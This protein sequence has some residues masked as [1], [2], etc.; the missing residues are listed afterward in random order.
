MGENGNGEQSHAISLYVNNKPG[1]L[2]RIGLVFS[3]RGWN[4]DSLCVSPGHDGHFSRMSIVA[5]GDAGRLHKIVSQLNKLVDVLHAE[6]HA[7]EEVITRDLALIKVG[8]AEAQHLD[9]AAVAE[10]YGGRRL[11]AT[12]ST[13]TFEF[14]GPPDVIE[15][16]HVALSL[17]FRVL[18]LVRSGAVVIAKG[19]LVT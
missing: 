12:D 18:E 11:H 14:V 5:K 17:G 3:R 8:A 6:E 15:Q 13:I 1:V 7:A 2:N 10:Q 16:A 4:I 9:V 19:E